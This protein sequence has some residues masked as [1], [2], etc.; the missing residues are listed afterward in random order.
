MRDRQDRYLAFV[1]FGA[2]F[3]STAIALYYILTH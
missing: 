3:I 2:V 1:S